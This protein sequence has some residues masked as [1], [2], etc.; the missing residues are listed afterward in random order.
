GGTA[1]TGSGS[2]TSATQDITGINITSLPDGTLTYSV[3]L[4]DTAGNT[5]AAATASGILDRV[6]PSGYTIAANQTLVNIP[7]STDTG[8]T[9]TKA[10]VGTTYTYTVTSSGGSGSVSGSGSVT[11]A[12]EQVTGVNVSSL[13]DGTLT[14]SVTLTDE[15]DNVGAAATATATLDTA[16]PSG[17][18]IT[19][20]RALIN[21]SQ[22]TS[23]GFTIANTTTGTTYNFTV[24][25]SGG[26]G[27]VSG[28]GNVTS[29]TQDITGINV[30]GLPDGTLTYSVTLANS[31]GNPGTAATATATLD[32]TAPHGYT[33][34]AVP[35]ALNATAATNAGFKFSDAEVDATY[36]FNITSSGGGSPITGN[37]SVTSATQTVNGI[38]ISSLNDGNLTYS[39]TLTDPAGN[40]GAAATASGILDRVAPSGY[41]IVA[42][43]TLV[44]IPTS[45][46]TGFTFSKAEVGTT[47]N[48]T[49]TSSGGTGS[50]SGSGSVSSATEQVTG[51]NVSSLSDGTLTFSVTLTDEADNVGAAATATATLNTTAPTGYTVTA[52]RALINASQATTTGF[53]IANTTTGTTY[54]FTVTS[55]GGTG[56]VSGNGSITSSTQDITGINVSGLPD[57]TLTYS[58]TLTNSIG[59]PGAAATATAT[60]DTTAPHG[61][62]ITAVPVALN[63]T[64]AT[65]AGFKFSDAEVNATYNFS[66]TS[67]GGGSPITGSGSVTVAT[68]TVS[69]INI[70]SLSDG[71]LTYSVTLTDPA[72]NV[73]LPTTASGILD[74]VAPSGYTIV[75]N[76]TLVNIPTSTNTGFTFTKAEVGTTYSYTVTSSG[77]TGSVTG[78]GSVT[79]ATEQVTGVNVSSLPAGTLTFSV[80]LTDEAGNIGSAAT[81]TTTLNTTVPT[82][83]SIAADQ[84]T[85]GPINDAAASFTIS[86][87]VVGETYSYSASSSGGAGTVSGGGAVTVATQQV[88]SINVSALPGGTLIYSVTLT[89]AL[90]NPGAAVTATATLDKTAPSGYTITAVPAILGVTTATAAGFSF[91]GAETGTTYSFSVTSNGGGTAVTGSGSVTSATQSVSGFSVS[92]LKDGTLTYSVTLTDAVGNVGLPA[93]TTADLERTPP[94]GYAIS[95]S[96]AVID[97]AASANVGF[98]FVGAVAGATY[99]FSITS[100]GG[101]A[102]VTGSGN[103]TSPTQQVT[104]INVSSLG[105]GVLTYSVT[106]TNAA[107][108]TG[109]AATVTATLAKTAPSGY[110][111]TP[112]EAT[113]NAV[114]SADAG[115]TFSGAE[116]GTTYNFTITSTGG[117]TAVTGSG[118]VTSATQDVTGINLKSLTN[119]TITI[120]VTLTDVEN[121]TGAPATTTAGLDR[122]APSAF[123]VTPDQTTYTADDDTNFG[124]TIA[125]AGVNDNY[126]YSILQGATAT[127]VQ[128]SGTATTA[129]VHL[130]GIDISSLAS[131]KCTLHVVLTNAVGNSTSEDATFTLDAIPN[132]TITTSLTAYGAA[133]ETNTGFTFSG[134]E[135]NT[136]YV[137]TV[138]SSGGSGSVTSSGTVTS[139]TQSVTGIN[140]SAL[141]DGTLTY[142]VKLTDSLD[143]TSSPATTTAVLDT[144]PPSGYSFTTDESIFNATTSKNA[145][146][147]F[148]KAEVGDE[149]VYVVGSDVNDATVSGTGTVTSASEHVGGIDI[150]SFPNGAITFTVILKDPAQNAGPVVQATAAIDTTLPSGYTI[151]ADQNIIGPT[152]ATN[153]GFTFTGA[154][155]GDSYDCAITSSGGG[156]VVTGSGSITSATQDIKPINVSVLPNGTLTYNVTLTSPDGN[157]G[158]VATATASLQAVAPS[159]FTVTPDQSTINAV[160]VSSSSFTL[161]GADV[162]ATYAYT[163]SDSGSSIT[164]SGNVTSA[165]QDITDINL[166]TLADGTATFSV[167]LTNTAGT[168]SPVTAT[169]TI[170]RTAPTEIALSTSVAL[171]NQPIG[172]L[173]GVLQTVGPQSTSD[174]TYSLVSDSGTND[175]SSFQISGDELQTD[176]IFTSPG[177]SYTIR[178][179]STDPQGEFIEQ[180]FL[181]TIGNTDPVTPTVS[182]NPSSND[183]STSS[184]SVSIA[185]NRT[186]AG[187]SVGALSTSSS[188]LGAQVNYTLVSGTGSDDN[189]LFQIVNGELETKG[190]LSANTTYTV[191]VRSSSTFLISDVVDLSGITGP[192]AYEV[193]LDPTQLPSGTYAQIAAAAGLIT[194]SSDPT[195]NWYPAVTTNTESPGS[196]AET[197][198]QGSYNSFWSSV[199]A[200][201]PSA[202]LKDVVGSSGIDL[203]ANEAWGVVDRPGEYAVGAQVYTEQVIT[204]KVT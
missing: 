124:F 7:A 58:V 112:D 125:S 105:D 186:S 199:T 64:A 92:S 156:G 102:A 131:G 18:T 155:V 103:V 70:S 16:A 5:G 49:V 128:G 141:K 204:I 184:T 190:T 148:S 66:I 111:I 187:T 97:L 165:T 167:T 73:G 89:N 201:N 126:S 151:A 135:I 113:F 56:S 40:V 161:T 134:A 150:S 59:N 127:S 166:S 38:N 21:A 183:T 72:G 173:V 170:D 136:T 158:A 189:S 65:N 129:T 17:Y 23:T 154:T 114:A 100:T 81:A 55:S 104:G 160:A 137:C 94:S 34:T 26:T 146:F 41:T 57:G 29:A 185:A 179:R 37:G 45:T 25:S 67:S 168:S 138:T 109:V 68:Q 96:P 202:T 9:F 28:S 52:D 36:T 15:A 144:V 176:A 163:I 174:Y 169:A 12:T 50:V 198:Y 2:V 142:S 80:T 11:S 8:F 119:G 19:A 140:V 200:A 164:G 180:Q 159:G 118:T 120:S 42:N 83:Y 121:N 20:D 181:I 79:S 51:V 86:G 171:A 152:D 69:G 14:F 123:T 98:T 122:V 35:A 108:D 145:G 130:T 4:T 153:A 95:A 192:T 1:V 85:L 30:S 78:S 110:S 133:T 175:N 71:N 74:R 101:G 106:L 54:N 47:Y 82:G 193:S 149:Y 13:K 182:I 196:L 27:L 147:T 162:G 76:Q 48:Y 39:V 172:T 24:T 84:A 178:V 43:Q 10:E 132:F 117:G 194:L 63:A 143:N 31:I 203:T 116:I 33:I 191:R 195:G 188:V 77:G 53:M 115:F 62:T 139:A 177:Q 32:T 87:G 90:G 99:Q 107:G 6:A 60:L 88:T 46:D 44:N 75:A 91:T 3:T 61:Y 197:N 22:A 157:T 93:T